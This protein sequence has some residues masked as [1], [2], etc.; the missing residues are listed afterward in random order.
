MLAWAPMCRPVQDWETVVFPALVGSELIAGLAMARMGTGMGLGDDDSVV[1]ALL[2]SG[3]GDD[4][5]SACASSSS[6]SR[7]GT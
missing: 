6:L 1:D 2:L 7:R 4:G 3:S 5:V